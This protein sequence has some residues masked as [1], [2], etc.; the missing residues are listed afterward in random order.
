ML[1]SSLSS[2]LRV[3]GVENGAARLCLLDRRYYVVETRK[4]A[5]YVMRAWRAA[6]PLSPSIF[7]FASFTVHARGLNL[8][9]T[10]LYPMLCC[11]ERLFV[12]VLAHF[13]I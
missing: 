6:S 2:S 4:R 1:A 9:P 13:T 12:M 3:A 8:H 10:N 5:R 7:H 11:R